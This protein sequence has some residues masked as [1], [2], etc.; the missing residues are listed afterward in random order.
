MKDQP[1]HHH[2][3]TVRLA[4]EVDGYNEEA[5]KAKRIVAG[6]PVCVQKLLELAIDQR[7]ALVSVWGALGI[8][9]RAAFQ[10]QIEK[11]PFDCS[12]SLIWDK[13]LVLL[14]ANLEGQKERI[15]SKGIRVVCKGL[16]EEMRGYTE[17]WRPTQQPIEVYV[18]D[19]F[20]VL[21]PL[22]ETDMVGA[23]ARIAE[24]VNSG[25]LQVEV[26]D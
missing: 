24:F 5:L 26:V 18:C 17:I 8:G 6:C 9:R 11:F 7:Y 19:G 2:A 25:K 21:I 10:A 16:E 1:L 13:P 22:G 20:D 15:K 14:R 4:L 12:G 23:C 3:L